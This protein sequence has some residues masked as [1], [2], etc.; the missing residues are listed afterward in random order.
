M[1]VSSLIYA[2]TS[3]QIAFYLWAIQLWESLT[4]HDMISLHFSHGGL[5]VPQKYRFNVDILNTLSITSHSSSKGSLFFRK[6]MF[7]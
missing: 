4:F 3:H 6:N 5:N 7:V 2:D 1:G